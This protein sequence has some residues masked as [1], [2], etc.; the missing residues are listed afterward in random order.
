MVLIEVYQ[1]V[2]ANHYR[3][4]AGKNRDLRRGPNEDSLLRL[5]GPVLIRRR[6]GVGDLHKVFD[7]RGEIIRHGYVA[8]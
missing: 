3:Q 6:L 4:T 1:Q 2:V 5:A 7:N 8:C